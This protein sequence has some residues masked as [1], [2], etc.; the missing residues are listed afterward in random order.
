MINKFLLA[1][2]TLMLSA[3]LIHGEEPVSWTQDFVFSELPSQ[4][5]PAW[6]E[7]GENSKIEKGV[8]VIDPAGREYVGWYFNGGDEN[9]GLWDG[10]RPSTI[11]FRMCTPKATGVAGGASLTISDGQKSYRFSFGNSEMRTYRITLENGQATIYRIDSSSAP[12]V[13]EGKD[14]QGARSGNIG[15]NAVTFGK[16]YANVNGISEWAYIRWTSEGA[17]RP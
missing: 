14:N 11:E 7:H 16:M 13:R 4:L 15:P 6:K 10:S 9:K 2:S 12:T 3:F 1:V 5:N 8:L 17:F